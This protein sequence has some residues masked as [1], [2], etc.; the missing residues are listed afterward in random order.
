M[1]INISQKK[2]KNNAPLLL[3]V[4]AVAALGVFTILFSKAAA[5]YYLATNGNDSNPCTQ[6]QPCKSFDRALQVAQ[7]GDTVEVA[8][9]TYA[10]QHLENV[11]GG[12]SGHVL[13][14]PANG[15]SVQIGNGGTNNCKGSSTTTFW[16]LCIEGSD[17]I[18]L[19]DFKVFNDGV[20]G[21]IGIIKSGSG[22]GSNDIIL[23]NLSALTVRMQ[24][25]M[26]N[27]QILGGEYGGDMTDGTFVHVSH[28]DT[29]GQF[30]SNITFD[31]VRF[32]DTRSLNAGDHMECILANAFTNL[33]LINSRFEMCGQ[34]GTSTANIHFNDDL[35]DSSGYTIRNNFFGNNAGQPE[36]VI[37][38]DIAGTK[39]FEFNSIDGA[40]S[41]TDGFS[42]G[43]MTVRGN[44]G[45]SINCV[46][47]VTYQYN[48][49]TG[50]ACSGT[51]NTQVG[52]L[53]FVNSS[54]S[55]WNLHLTAG[56][57]AIGKVASNCPASDI[58]GQ[59]RPATNCDAGA[60]QYASGGGTDT[61]PPDT[62]ITS[63]TPTNG[64]STTS[65]TASA[66]FT[67]TD[68]IGV[69]SF[70]CSLDST[71]A[72]STCTSPKSY[73]SLTTG[74]HTIRV[75]AKDAAGNTDQ[76]PATI[77]F[78]V[79]AGSSSPTNGLLGTDLSFFPIGVWWQSPA[80]N[81]GGK[82]VAK[83]YADIGINTMLF[84]PDRVL[85]SGDAA[86]M[87]A[88]GVYSVGN[89]QASVL[90]TPNAA[91]TKA[92]TQADE[93]D[94][95]QWNSNTQ[96]Y[97]PCISPSV[98]VGKYNTLKAADPSRP[99]WINFGQ[100]VANTDWIGRGTCTGETGM[101]A[102]YA[103][104]A[105]ILS[106]DVYPVNSGYPLTYV[107][108]GVDN[109]RNWTGDT[110][111]VWAYLEVTDIEGTT[112]PTATHVKM[113]AWS[114]LVHGAKG[115]AYFAHAFSPSF[116]ERGLL[117]DTAMST[118]VGAIN[119]QIKSLAP[120]LNS[121]TVANG[122]TVS[123]SAR[124]DKMVKQYNNETYLFAVGMTNTA[125][126]GN[127]HVNGLTNGTVTVIG[128]NRT[129]TMTNGNFSDSFGG[130]GVH[131]YKINQTGTPTC[132]TLQ[133]DTNDD[134]VVNIS[135]ISAILALFGQTSTTNCADVTKDQTINIQD[136]SLVLAKYG[137]RE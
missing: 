121:T 27:I 114:A 73:T 100:G 107:A 103:A 11:P 90:G 95:A 30:P 108:D 75:R 83:A 91:N 53:N 3:V 85:D 47:G 136:I 22:V 97:D 82:T 29:E 8:A 135:D 48:V 44:Y 96:T 50:S 122:A 62:S 42:G 23:R 119:A 52:S 112:K 132:S 106:F 13:F 68:N 102:Q 21:A 46:S 131:L 64:A 7:R 89:T 127:F 49:T 128:E 92:W 126:T 4:A 28:Y 61:T 134:G 118:A 18:E 129:L 60:D 72:Y 77:S 39:I 84:P 17:W 37:N 26:D 123:S 19:R 86:A 24:G 54:A 38:G 66:S 56:A 20:K 101:Y 5:N 93:P 14:R 87:L 1:R 33:T 69:T 116:D 57:N 36:V 98:I 10:A 55:T 130:Y 137:N 35:G 9:G 34:N 63:S 125:T 78:T 76:S 88:A 113:E 45:G 67:G 120:V 74:T 59:N 124:I 79:T 58:D 12:T 133:G 109:L 32:Y 110:K 115:L 43:P 81:Y 80:L 117:N 51:G 111:P 99:V 71:T 15:A 104:G 40:V 31:G 65:T 94:N 41:I 2:L 6:S 105:D 16:Q 70:E 25:R